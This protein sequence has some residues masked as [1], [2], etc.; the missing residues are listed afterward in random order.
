MKDRD[1]I[2]FGKTNDKG[3]LMFGNGPELNKFLS[4]WPNQNFVMDITIIADGTSEAL[5]GYYK[6]VIVPEFQKAYKHK[7]GERLTLGQV[8]MRLRQM[9][10]IMH[11]TDKEFNL[12][13]TITIEAAGNHRASEFID[14]LIFLGAENFGIAIKEPK[15]N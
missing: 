12:K 2:L 6:R 4:Q 11:E 9:S 1:F 10:A 13:Y 15:I 14:D 3:Q 7:Q 5:I 8:D